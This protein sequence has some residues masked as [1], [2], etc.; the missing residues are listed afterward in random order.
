[1]CRHTENLAEY[2]RALFFAID[3]PKSSKYSSYISSSK[4][5][6]FKDKS[7]LPLLTDQNKSARLQFC[8]S[9]V[10]SNIRFED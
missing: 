10:R 1:M 5:K 9:K 6:M 3:V 8:F 4:K 2:Q 7:S